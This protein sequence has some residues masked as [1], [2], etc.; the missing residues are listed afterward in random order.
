MAHTQL[1]FDLLDAMRLDGCPICRLRQRALE[2]YVDTLLYERVNDGRLRARLRRSCGFCHEHAWALRRHGASVG[3]A[4]MMRDVLRTLLREGQAAQGVSVARERRSGV[5]WQLPRWLRRRPHSGNWLAEA[6][7]PRDTC[8]I[9]VAMR[10]VERSCAAVMGETILERDFQ[11]AFSR[12]EGLCRAHLVLALER[13]RTGEAADAL[14]QAEKGI[15]RNLEADLSELIR[16]SDYR[17]MAEPKGAEAK[18]W[19]RALAA[20]SGEAPP[21]PESITSTHNTDE[22]H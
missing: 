9:C 7:Q 4:L 15:W 5:G 1:Y 11:D 14:W 20:I 16:K 19:L 18:S 3:V 2:R 12:S 13:A 17:F 6:L 22:E 10:D 21:L 8:P